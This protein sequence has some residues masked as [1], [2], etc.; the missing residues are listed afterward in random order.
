MKWI[1]RY[2]NYEIIKA[3]YC[4]IKLVL[5]EYTIFVSWFRM[6]LKTLAFTGY[7]SP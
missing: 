4:F 7:Y 2:S 5:A 6:K 3:R 1:K